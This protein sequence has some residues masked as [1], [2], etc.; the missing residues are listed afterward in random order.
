MAAYSSNAL[1][2]KDTDLTDNR[3]GV[4]ATS[5][6]LVMISEPACSE[7]DI[8]E[9]NQTDR[10]CLEQGKRNIQRLKITKS[11]CVKVEGD[12]VDEAQNVYGCDDCGKVYAK[13][14]SWKRHLK[15][16]QPGIQH[17]GSCSMYFDSVEL[18]ESHNKKTH[19]ISCR[20]KICGLSVARKSCLRK[21]MLRVHPEKCNARFSCPQSPCKAAF[22]DEESYNDHL[23]IHNGNKPHNC[24]H[25]QKSFST[26]SSLKFH[27]NSHSGDRKSYQCRDC[28]KT[29]QSP[30][31]LHNHKVSVHEKKRFKCDTC[32]KV[33]IYRS[34][35]CKH[36]I[37]HKKEKS[38][39]KNAQS[40]AV[41]D[42]KCDDANVKNL[43]DSRA[44]SAATV[45]QVD[46]ISSHRNIEGSGQ[47]DEN[48][49]DSNQ[50]DQKEVTENQHVD[51]INQVE[52]SQ[53]NVPQLQTSVL[54]PQEMTGLPLTTI[55][56]DPS[57]QVM[58][59]C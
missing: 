53:V 3:K 2:D 57:G 29:F 40:S 1:L 52:I 14:S 59:L 8:S 26:R 46:G 50:R 22:D 16:H 7:K 5:A 43:I 20:C 35:Y 30:G 25:C 38:S 36:L 18:L 4:A 9:K 27:E 23:N 21:H 48:C 51:N 28:R 54:A 6:Q 12:K 15:S 19:S 49:S 34:G 47:T 32:G 39:S 37:S 58:W 41:R 11:I 10:Y 42:L 44:G 56:L 45:C 31:A 33:F 24:C 17:C 13:R 55:Q